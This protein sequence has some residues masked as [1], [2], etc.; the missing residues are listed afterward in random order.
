MMFMVPKSTDTF[1]S[2]CCKV[3]RMFMWWIVTRLTVFR[4]VCANAV[5]GNIELQCY[6]PER[7]VILYTGFIIKKKFK[8]NI[9]YQVAI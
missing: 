7:H 9:W 8:E 3:K 4:T 5:C 2:V 6:T 1:H